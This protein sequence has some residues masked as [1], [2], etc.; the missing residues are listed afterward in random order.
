MAT[1]ISFITS[2]KGKPLLIRDN[3][4]YYVSKT[5]ATVKYWK[6]EDRSCNAG[7]HTNI[8]DAFIKIVGNHSHLQS[9]E[10]IEVR[11]FKQNIKRRV[12]NEITVITKIYDEELAR[13]PMSQTAAASCIIVFLI[14]G[15]EEFIYLASSFHHH[16][17]QVYSGLNRA[18]RKMTPI[19]PKSYVFNIP[20]QY[21]VTL[22]DEQFLLCDKTLHTKRLLLFGYPCVIGLLC[23]RKARTYTQLFCELKHHATRLKTIFNPNTITSDFEKALIKAVAGE[24]PQAQHASCYFHFT[25]ALYRNIQNLGLTTAYRDTE[26]TRIVCRK[27]MAL[28]L[29]QLNDIELAFEDLKDD[30]PVTLRDLFKYFE[31]FWMTGIPLHLWNVSDLQ[32]RRNNNC[33]G[34]HNRFN[35][36]VN[37]HHPN[38]WHFIN[39]LKQEEVYFRHQVIQIRAGATGRQKTKKTNC[40]QRRIDTLGDRHEN[41]EITLEEYLEGLSFV[42]A[43]DKTKKINKK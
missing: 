36:R 35:I 20:A 21:Q 32:I 10:E 15:V 34:W 18:R 11:T 1:T 27:L 30:S 40:V 8:Q 28:P 6:C 23:D 12:I 7:V 25:Q 38:I 2:N 19:L 13:Q 24:F 9:P 17:K 22:G 29:L 37:K 42:V 33:E 16:M 31:N 26:S 14:G 4:I 39:C 3:Y 41:D 5:T 43:K